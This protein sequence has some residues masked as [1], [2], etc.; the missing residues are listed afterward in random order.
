M[1]I[2][3]LAH[4]LQHQQQMKAGLFTLYVHGRM[5]SPPET[6]WYNRAIEADATATA[7]DIAW[8]LKEAGKSAAWDYVRKHDQCSEAARAYAKVAAADPAA[9]QDG[10][11]KRAAFDSWFVQRQRRDMGQTTSQAY[12]DPGLALVPQAEAAAGW[13]QQG[14]RTD[15]LT[16]ADI[17]KLGDLAP[18][19]YL[20]I[21]G[22]RPLDDIYYRKADWNMEEARYLS[23]RTQEYDSLKKK[24]NVAAARKQ[25]AQS[26]AQPAGKPAAFK[27]MKIWG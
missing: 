18:F 7:V 14:M 15:R 17:E 1:L 2:Y 13:L 6:V 10:R 25:D 3:T 8:K 9:V 20:K 22:G 19:N 4:E 16:A 23:L 12:N 11:A 24:F 27:D 21:P 26:A 5:P